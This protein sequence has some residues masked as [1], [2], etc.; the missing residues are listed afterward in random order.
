MA[1]ICTFH[2]DST[3]YRYRRRTAAPAAGSSKVHE[4][5]QQAVL[6]EALR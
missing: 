6:D 3:N 2:L 1:C 5:E 4:V